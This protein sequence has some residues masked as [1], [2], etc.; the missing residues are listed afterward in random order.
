MSTTHTYVCPLRDCGFTLDGT[1]IIAGVDQHEA[2]HLAD[3]DEIRIIHLAEAEIIKPTHEACGG[4]IRIILDQ[5]T[6]YGQF[7][8]VQRSDYEISVDK[9]HGVD[10]DP[11]IHPSQIP[12]LI[13]ELERL[14]HDW[15]K[16]IHPNSDQ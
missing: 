10:D 11:S 6:E 2:A 16:R 3:A 4:G 5:I 12:D 8:E 14:H 15:L 1:D 13:V 9:A 7:G